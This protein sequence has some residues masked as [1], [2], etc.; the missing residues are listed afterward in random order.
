MYKGWTTSKERPRAVMEDQIMEDMHVMC[1]KLW[2]S[3]V[4]RQSACRLIVEEAK[5]HPGLL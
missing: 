2:G 1:V 3:L 5:A 4:K